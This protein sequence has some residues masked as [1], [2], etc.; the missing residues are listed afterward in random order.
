L[1]YRY[2]IYLSYRRR[3]EWPDWVQAHFEPLLAHWLGEELG[4]GPEIF[5]DARDV[6]TGSVWPDTLA[7]GLASSRAMVC[8]WSRS[9]FGSSWCVAE[10]SHMLERQD[11]TGSRL[12][13]PATIHDG[14][15]IPETLQYLQVRRLNEYSNPRMTRDSPS[16]E[17]L[18]EEIR[19]FAVAVATAVER[20]PTYQSRWAGNA[21]TGI[22]DALAGSVGPESISLPR[23]AT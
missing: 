10:L 23:I 19:D 15:R 1:D 9:Y 16:S 3:G 17:R 20:A 5:F 12:V 13:V 8:L 18:S 11:Q 2:D 22:H 7:D 21:R 4:R 6:E 14:D